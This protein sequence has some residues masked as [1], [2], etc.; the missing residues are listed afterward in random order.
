MSCAYY[1]S[2]DLGSMEGVLY[3]PPHIPGFLGEW[4]FSRSACQ[5]VISVLAEFQPEWPQEYPEQNRTQNHPEWNLGWFI[6]STVGPTS[7][8]SP[9]PVVLPLSH[10]P[11]TLT[12]ATRSRVAKVDAGRGHRPE[13]LQ[14]CTFHRSLPLFSGHFF[15]SA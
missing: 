8:Q 7:R 4:N 3:S 5:I 11:P 10:K 15:S 2:E 14:N 9:L 13:P 12:F 6:I 1:K